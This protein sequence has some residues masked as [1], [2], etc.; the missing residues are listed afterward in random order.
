MEIQMFSLLTL[1]FIGYEMQTFVDPKSVKSPQ[2]PALVAVALLY[3]VWSI[4][5]LFTGYR[6]YFALLLTVSLLNFALKRYLD[7]IVLT[8]LDSL[9]SLIILFTMFVN[10]LFAL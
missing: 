2:A 8:R 7:E 1:I 6:I 9:V 10:M 3:A 4:V 5:G